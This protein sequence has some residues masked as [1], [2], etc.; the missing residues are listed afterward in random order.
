MKL[1]I[2]MDSIKKI[3]V[4]KDSSF[5]ILL[6]AQKKGFEIYYMEIQDLYLKN[7]CAKSSAKLINLKKDN[8]EWFKFKKDKNIFLDELDVILIRKDPP[9]NE[10]FM[11]L[12]HILDRIKHNTLIIN[13]PNSLRKFNEKI[14][15]SIF[16]PKTPETLITCKKKLIFDFLKDNKEIIIKPLNKMGGFSVFY[17]N[18]NDINL[19]VILENMTNKEKKFCLVQKFI[20]SV[21]NGDKR[22]FIINGKAIKYCLSRIPS[23]GEIRANLSSGG[24]GK[25]EIINKNDKKIIKKITPVLIKNKI[26][27]AGIDIIGNFLTEINITSPTCMQEIEKLS[28]F[29]ISNYIIKEIKREIT[30]M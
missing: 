13:N 3:N 5:S 11:Y 30:C 7:N 21:F 8:I 20:P 28:N 24:K 4:N 16:Y 26:F 19:N 29:S 12:T 6:S 17:L 15:A 10:K 1:G 14:F 18:V 27:I 23:K 22:I 2:I 25:L 9:F